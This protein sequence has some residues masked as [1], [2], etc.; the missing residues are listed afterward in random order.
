MNWG[1]MQKQPA[2]A[3]GWLFGTVLWVSSALPFSLRTFLPSGIEFVCLFSK[4]CNSEL[5]KM[6]REAL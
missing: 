4:S 2:P 3:T 1:L 6:I 5:A